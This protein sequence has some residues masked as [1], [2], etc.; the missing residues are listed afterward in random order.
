MSEHTNL[1]T[2]KP[3]HV[4][5]LDALI[6]KFLVDT[7]AVMPIPNPAFDPAKYHPELEGKQTIKDKPKAKSAAKPKVR[8]H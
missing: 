4:L 6:E 1:A 2:H 7:K 3:E 8:R 5:E